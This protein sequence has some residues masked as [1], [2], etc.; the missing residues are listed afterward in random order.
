MTLEKNYLIH[1]VFV[2]NL[3]PLSR[4]FSYRLGK[5][6]P[7]KSILK[8]PYFFTFLNGKSPID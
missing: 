3:E 8:T 6:I 2:I 4:D 5:L 7:Q 1:L